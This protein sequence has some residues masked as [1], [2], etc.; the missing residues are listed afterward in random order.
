VTVRDYDMNVLNDDYGPGS[1]PFDDSR[2]YPGKLMWYKP[3]D[4]LHPN[5]TYGEE[6]LPTF[7]MPRG[8]KFKI[9]YY[10][11]KR[12]VYFQRIK[13]SL[14]LPRCLREIEVTNLFLQHDWIRC[15]SINQEPVGDEFYELLGIEKNKDYIF[16][17]QNVW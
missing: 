11:D 10:D 7:V 2:S 5:Y 1:G 12:A 3:H 16:E 15:P 17:F 14:F 4:N 9:D 8:P 6:L 13:K